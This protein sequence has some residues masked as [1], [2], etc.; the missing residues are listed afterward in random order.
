[1]KF[2]ELKT[3]IL[4]IATA[5]RDEKKRNEDFE[6]ALKDAEKEILKISHLEQELE[7]LRNVHERGS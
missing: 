2:N 1:M 4:N 3:R 6:Q 7:D 5:Y